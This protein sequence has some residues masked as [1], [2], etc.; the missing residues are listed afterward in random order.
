MLLAVDALSPTGAVHRHPLFLIL[1]A[2]LFV[3]LAA[4]TLRRWERLDLPVLLT[5][6]G[7]LLILAGAAVTWQ[8]AQR[9]HLTLRVG[10]EPSRLVHPKDGGPAFPLPFETRLLDFRLEYD[11]APR[12]VVRWSDP[13]T[14]RTGELEG[15]PP[16]RH[17]L[18]SMG[19]TLEVLSFNPDLVVG[20]KGVTQRSNQPRNPALLVRWLEGK[21]ASTPFWLFA[22]YPDAHPSRGALS[23]AYDFRPA[24]LRQYVSVVALRTNPGDP[25]TK[26]SLWVN[27]PLR[28]Q[29]WT[30]YQ[31]AYDPDDPGSSTLEAA[32]DPGIYPVYAG[33]AIL[34]LGLIAVT[35]RRKP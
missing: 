11:G 25:E 2:L 12:H 13:T 1:L 24:P 26:A 14:G 27:R 22:L 20:A 21:K 8:G 5:H 34:L 29:G 15:P 7:A 31:S 23:L 17:A 10:D 33:F 3:N 28:H 9:G 32:R 6:L 18:P 16:I 30:L 19:V 35:F 4:C